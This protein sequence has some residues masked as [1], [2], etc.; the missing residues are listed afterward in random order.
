VAQ[1]Y[2]SSFG[3]VPSWPDGEFAFDGNVDFRDLVA[4]AQNYNTSF[5][6]ARDHLPIGATPQLAADW[7]TATHAVAPEPGAVMSAMGVVMLLWQRT[8]RRQR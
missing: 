7:R 5:T 8:G 1:N 6:E 2:G 3:Q 4:L